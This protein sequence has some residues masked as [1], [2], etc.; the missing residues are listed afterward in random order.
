M[1]RQ[2]VVAAAADMAADMAAER[3]TAAVA[4]P[5]SVVAISAVAVGPISVV[6]GASAAEPILVAAAGR[7]S[8]AAASV[9]SVVAVAEPVLLADPRYHGL[10][11]A[12]VCVRNARSR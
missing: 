8:A 2:E 12:Q 1:R 5:I 3:R 4:E 7:V 11:H 6:E 9:T 10:R